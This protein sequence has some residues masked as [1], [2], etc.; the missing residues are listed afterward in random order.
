MRPNIADLVKGTIYDQLEDHRDVKTY[1]SVLGMKKDL[2]FI[3][4]NQS[5]KSV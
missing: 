1:P 5:E 3:S 4:H 2:F